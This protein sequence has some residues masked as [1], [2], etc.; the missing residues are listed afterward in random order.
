[1]P[2]FRVYLSKCKASL[3]RDLDKTMSK[4]V[5]MLHQVNSHV[6]VCPTSAINLKL[7]WLISPTSHL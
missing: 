5:E 1:M 7:I 4:E 2:N 6:E 3:M